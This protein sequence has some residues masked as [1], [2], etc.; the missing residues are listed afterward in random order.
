MS[1]RSGETRRELGRYVL[2]DQIAAGGMATVH[3]ARMHG[4]IGFSRL[5]AIKR[6]H[7]SYANDPDRVQMFLDEARLAARLDH[8][9]VVSTLDVIADETEVFLVMEHILGQALEALMPRAQNAPIPLPIVSAIIC[10]VL[11]GLHAAHEARAD[12]GEPL[13]IVH[14][15][16]SPHN[17]LVGA[18]GV[19]RVFDFGIA[20][21]AINTQE[22]REGV[23]KGKVTY[24]APEQVWG[25]AD[26]R[27][28]LY[29][30]G[31]IL[32]E[33]VGGRRRHAGEHNDTLF[34]KLARNELDAPGP[35]TTMRTD[36]PEALDAIVARATEP[37]ARQRFDTARD[38]A[39]ALEEAIAPAP[40]RD[41]ADWLRDVAGSR[42]DRISSVMRRIE[43]DSQSAPA[44]DSLLTATMPRSTSTGSIHVV[45]ATIPRPK[46]GSLT[47]SPSQAI[48]VRAS[49]RPTS[50]PPQRSWTMPAALLAF[51]AAMLLVGLR[52]L[53]RHDAPPSPAS[54]ISDAA[55][56]LS[57]T[58]ATAPKVQAP[59]SA[60]P[61]AGS[62][63]SVA[64]VDAGHA[65]VVSS[66]A[67]VVQP[68]RHVW[69]APTPVVRSPS[70]DTTA[71][72]PSTRGETPS[73]SATSGHKPGC[74]S[75]F[76]IG[77]DGIR[78]IKPECL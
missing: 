10:G 60:L 3:F 51:T 54:A 45:T 7:P 19:A 40:T 66:S 44:P 22:T 9:N 43:S 49:Q 23:V 36:V 30:A 71:A 69:V 13:S 4:A 56:D 11:E 6:L 58:T 50:P 18:D 8:P 59:P 73:A 21:A 20:K 61:S 2:Y 64:S 42:I 65:R 14:R 37:D 75:P 62:T 52:T 46:T 67:S 63:A 47:S 27:A 29:A 28:D 33:L 26:R 72:P 68:Q 15:D 74:E 57:T 16:V 48:D 76:A 25:S 12:T 5:V 41:V 53:R 17:I 70:R 35:L 34:L 32:W 31:V 78:E 24:M 55:M 1:Q 38:M 39:V 77:P